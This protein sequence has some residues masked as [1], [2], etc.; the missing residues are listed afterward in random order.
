MRDTLT[1]AEIWVGECGNAT[2]RKRA[3]EMPGRAEGVA[4]ELLGKIQTRDGIESGEKKDE[5]KREGP[6]VQHVDAFFVFF[7]GKHSPRNSGEGV[8]GDCAVE[9][10]VPRQGALQ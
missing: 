3:A 1:I 10:S 4:G 2:G 5:R 9:I 6:G 7:A 8:N